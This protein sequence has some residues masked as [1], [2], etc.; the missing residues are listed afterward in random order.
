MWWLANGGGR[1]RQFELQLGRLETVV[2]RDGPIDCI[3]LGNSMVWLGFDPEAFARTYRRQA[4]EGIRCFNFGVDGMPTVSAGPLASILARDYQPRLM[5]YG[6]SARDYSLSKGTSE[7]TRILEL[8]WLQYRLGQFSIQGWFHDHS[9]LYQYQE[10]L[11][12]VL[13][14][15]ERY[16]LLTRYHD[17]L[18]DDYGFYRKE[19]VGEFVSMPPDPRSEETQIRGL[20]GV[21]SDYEMLP[22]NLS[23][24]E[25]IVGQN[26]YGIQVLIVEMPVPP[27]YLHFFG[28][29]QQDH[30]R[31][32]DQME[33]VAESGAVQFWPT[34]QLWLIP[35]DGW[36]DYAHLNTKGARVFSEWLG[37]QL[38]MAVVQ[39]KLG[40][41]G[42]QR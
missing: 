7:A 13:R 37:A 2:S 40:S 21:L 24:L 20:F 38:G 35:D 14:F 33:R 8:P 5:I 10:S 12:H 22:E 19:T 39:G 15:D 23:G 32:I 28:N 26:S 29:G 30:Q 27:T 9:R 31:F 16:L 42:R 41:P 34:T 1:H 3:F 6:T 36:A 18:K 17:S 4:G 11:S 25:Q